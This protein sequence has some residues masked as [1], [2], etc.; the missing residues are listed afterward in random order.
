MNNHTTKMTQVSIE[1]N[2]HLHFSE[3]RHGKYYTVVEVEN[4]L[5]EIK[6]LE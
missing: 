2:G 5:P 1:I 6:I 4:L 3:I